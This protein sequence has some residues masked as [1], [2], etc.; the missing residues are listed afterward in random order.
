MRKIP[1]L[2]PSVDRILWDVTEREALSLVRRGQAVRLKRAVRLTEHVDDTP[3][4]TCTG[5]GGVRRSE[6][7][8]LLAACG[9]SQDYTTRNDRG[10]VNGF[11]DIFLEDLPIFRAAVLDCI[12]KQ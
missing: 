4:R 10:R 3:M 1:V 7:S 6:R 2:A 12:T 11:K 8:N 9:Q 5:R